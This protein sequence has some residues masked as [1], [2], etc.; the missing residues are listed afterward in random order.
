MTDE[1]H[2]P[3]DPFAEIPQKVLTLGHALAHEAART[4]PTETDGDA[5]ALDLADVSVLRGVLDEIAPLV[6]VDE[7]DFGLFNETAALS[8]IVS[9]VAADDSVRIDLEAVA[10]ILEGFEREIVEGAKGLRLLHRGESVSRKV[11]DLERRI[12]V[13]ALSTYI[14]LCETAGVDHEYLDRSKAVIARLGPIGDAEG[15]PDNDTRRYV[16]RN[17]IIAACL[18]ALQ[19]AGLVPSN[20]AGEVAKAFGL[21]ESQVMRAWKT[22]VN[23]RGKTPRSGC[24]CARCGKPAGEDALRIQSRGSLSEDDWDLVCRECEP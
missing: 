7:A 19:D 20:Y 9:S 5:T 13:D 3:R 4:S 2:G 18:D 23:R 16:L 22:A 17:A 14:V 10:A 8:A 6:V 12:A 15:N 11:S 24:R 21:S 1:Q